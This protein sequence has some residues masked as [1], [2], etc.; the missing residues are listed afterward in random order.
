[1]AQKKRKKSGWLRL[2]FLCLS[3]PIL[4]WV[5]VFFVWFFWA[6]LTRVFFKDA[7][8]PPATAKSEAKIERKVERVDED[9]SAQTPAIDRAPEKLVDEE[10]QKL[11]A[12]IKRLQQ[13]QAGKD[14]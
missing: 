12:I 1:M 4:V 14:G 6:D 7:A 8:K 2:L 11:D 9:T 13:R 10:R 3:F 5:G